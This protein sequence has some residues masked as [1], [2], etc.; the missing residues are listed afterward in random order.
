MKSFLFTD[1]KQVGE[2]IETSSLRLV[3]QNNIQGGKMI[4]TNKLD[5]IFEINVYILK[6]LGLKINQINFS[7][8]I[9]F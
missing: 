1:I 3:V 2:E 7:V 4:L 9:Q 5:H 8:R 6:P